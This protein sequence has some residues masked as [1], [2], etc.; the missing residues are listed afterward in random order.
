MPLELSGLGGGF[1]WKPVVAQLIQIERIPQTKIQSKKTVNLKEQTAIGDLKSRLED[2]Q[3]ALEALKESKTFHGRSTSVIGN[4]ANN[5]AFSA[6]ADN[7]ALT[8]NYDF[9][10]TQLA[11]KSARTGA[12]NIGARLNTTND[13]SG[14]TV[15]L[16]NTNTAITEGSFTVNGKTVSLKTTDSLQDVFDAISTATGGD[17]TGA[18]DATTDKITLSSASEIVLG[19]PADSSNFLAATKLYSN[20]TGTVA[21]QTSL[22]AAGINSAVDKAKL[23]VAVSAGTFTVNG[24]T[25]TVNATDSM[26]DIFDAISTATSGSVTASY[27][28]GTEKI[29]LSSGSAITLGDS[30]DTSN[31]LA[32]TKL[33]ANGTGT[34]NSSA[35]V[36]PI[37]LSSAINTYHLTPPFGQTFSAGTFTVNG[38][39]VT[40]NA[41]D[42]LADIF[43][44]IS[45]ATSGDVT[46]TYD[47]TSQKI[48]L[49]SASTITVGNGADTSNFLTVAQLSHDPDN[50]ATSLASGGKLGN[51]DTVTAI[52]SLT[53]TGGSFK[54]NGKTITYDST[55]DSLSA[56]ITRINSSEANANMTYDALNDR[57]VMTNNKTGSFD[58]S[59]EDDSGMLMEAMG[60]LGTS[61]LSK[62]VNAQYTVNGG[63]TLTSTSNDFDST[64]H[65]ITGLTVT[66]KKTGVTET[67]EVTTDPAK[68]RE[69]IDAFIEKYNIAQSYIAMKTKTTIETDKDGKTVIKKEDLS[70]YGEATS[71][72]RNL[73]TKAFKTVDGLAGDVKRLADMGIDFVKGSNELEVKDEALLTKALKNEGSSVA[74]LFTQVA[75]T[76]ESAD[77]DQAESER[78]LYA[79]IDKIIEAYVSYDGLFKKQT[80][81]ITATNKRL[82]DQIASLE[83]H[84]KSE[85]KRLKASFLKMELAQQKINTQ[86]QVLSARLGL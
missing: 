64:S 50:A 28:S 5:L 7:G 8:G 25:V 76:D 54:V 51:I 22:G 53:V 66:A 57:F 14:L 79:S 81:I 86:S 61:S 41:G 85:E 65:G 47:S 12:S 26:Q 73:R 63:G 2:V 15:E 60:L 45:T 18:Y 17:V 38:S 4:D 72:A 84:I 40:V 3:K 42:T 13:V 62:G 33:T 24:N 19:T 82:D 16:M 10:V 34:V 29:T 20:G 23:G 80:D 48:G 78:G 21:S 68:T 83:R 44:S 11:T 35:A 43:S 46:A 31:F 75:T 9:N 30:G 32:A 36:G 6:K 67:V 70:D 49:S 59:I 55:V 27:N 58:V 74:T 39:T 52:E 69:K 37:T 77:A 71:I 1:D 56:I